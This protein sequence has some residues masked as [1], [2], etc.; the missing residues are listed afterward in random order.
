VL[1]PRASAH[2]VSDQAELLTGRHRRLQTSMMVRN[3]L[4]RPMGSARAV[5]AGQHKSEAT[6]AR[7]FD[8]DVAGHA[9][10]VVIGAPHIVVTGP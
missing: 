7:L 10:P 6:E 3:P 8:G 5:G 9:R 4:S 1:D 2:T